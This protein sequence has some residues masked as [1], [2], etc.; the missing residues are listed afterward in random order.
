[1]HVAH[2]ASE[3]AALTAALGRHAEGAAPAVDSLRIDALTVVGTDDLV[4][5]LEQGRYAQRLQLAPPA[6]NELA[7]GRDEPELDAPAAAAGPLP[8]RGGEDCAADGAGAARRARGGAGREGD[9]R[10]R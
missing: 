7:V 1:P 3:Q 4:R 9:S 8:N 2:A 5:P 10:R 6:A